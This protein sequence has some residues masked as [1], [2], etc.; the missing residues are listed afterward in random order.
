VRK[1]LRVTRHLQDASSGK[2]LPVEE[3]VELDV[4]PGW[5]S[6][7]RITFEGKG[8]ELVGRCGRW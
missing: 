3:I 1:K 6:G 2:S 4:K 8:D 7:T 5:K